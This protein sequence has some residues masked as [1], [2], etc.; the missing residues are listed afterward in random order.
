MMSRIVN[1]VIPWVVGAAI[2]WALVMAAT[3]K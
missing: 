1:A 3:G 2:I